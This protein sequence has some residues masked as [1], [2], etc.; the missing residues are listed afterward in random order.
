MPKHSIPTARHVK[1]GRDVSP[2]RPLRLGLLG[3]ASLRKE[4]QCARCVMTVNSGSSSIKFALYP[5]DS[6]AKQ[7]LSGRI[8]RIGL[9]KP[10]L[11]IREGPDRSEDHTSE[12]QSPC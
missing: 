5:T 9:P 12:L 3:E 6:P 4:V 10:V 11:T 7:L 2:R 1:T 8:E